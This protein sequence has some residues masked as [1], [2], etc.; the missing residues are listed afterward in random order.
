MARPPTVELAPGVWRLPLLGDWV[1]GFAFR[2]SDGQVTLLDMGLERHGPKVLAALRSIGS[3]PADVT[4]LLLTHAHADHAGGAALVARETGHGFGVHEDDAAYA[5]DGEVPPGDPSSRLGRVLRRF[6]AQPGFD[7]VPVAEEL[8]R[9][10]GDPGRRRTAGRPHARPLPRPLLLP[11]RGVRGPRDRGRDLQRAATA[12]AGQGLL[13]RLRDDEADGPPAGRAGLRGGGLHARP[14]DPRRRPRG[15]TPVP[16]PVRGSMTSRL[17]Q[18]AR[19]RRVA[20]AAIARYDLPEGRLRFVTH[21]ENTT[22]RHDSTAGT[23]LVRVHRPQRHGR[24]VDSVAAIRSEIAWLLAIRDETDLAVPEPLAAADGAPVVEATAAGE[25]RVCSVLRWMD[26]RI[27]EESARP[28][29]LRRLGEAMARLHHQADAWTPPPD[30]VRIRWDHETFFGDVMVYGETS[31]AGCWALLPADVRT[32]FESV[33]ARTADLMERSGDWGLIHADLHLGNAL[34]HRGGHQ[35]DRLRRLRTRP[36]PLRPRRRPV[37][38]AGRAGLRALPGRA[39]GGLPVAARTSTSPTS[40][41]SSPYGR[42]PST[43]GTRARPRST[44]SSPP[45]WTAC[46]GGRWRCSTSSRGR[47]ALARPGPWRRPR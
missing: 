11:P 32:R 46:T 2:D 44:R 16:R 5:R 47:P 15:R 24:D 17:A 43:S 8:G 22:F 18:I 13:H 3:G 14:G 45:G 38:A 40:T 35:A 33:A 12:L 26:G 21:G 9:R 7:A 23:Y 42:S 1:N 36:P 41:T 29:H 30:F 37:G 39:A 25:T 6:G 10:D 19:L 28:V 27:H 20:L 31:A 4:R 34:F